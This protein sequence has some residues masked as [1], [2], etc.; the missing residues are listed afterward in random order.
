[1]YPQTPPQSSGGQA[2][3]PSTHSGYFALGSTGGVP[4]NKTSCFQPSPKSYSYLKAKRLPVLGRIWLS[5]V[6]VESTHSKSSNPSSSSSGS[7]YLSPL[8]AN[9]WRWL[10]VQ[11]IEVWMC[12]CN[13]S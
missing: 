3:S 4:S 1:P 6:F 5:L 10:L 7:P 9:W 12:S 11:P 8:M 2:L 13:L